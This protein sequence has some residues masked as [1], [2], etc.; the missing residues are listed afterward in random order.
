[1]LQAKK[2]E[3][4]YFI[5]EYSLLCYR[6]YRSNYDNCQLREDNN[7]KFVFC[8]ENAPLSNESSHLSHSLKHEEVDWSQSRITYISPEFTK[9]QQHAIGFKDLGIQLW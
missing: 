2:A 8:D 7:Y 1:M 6:Y 9:Y 5:K 4:H 3:D